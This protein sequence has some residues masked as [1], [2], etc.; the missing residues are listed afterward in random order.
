LLHAA[1]GVESTQGE[2]SS[3]YVDIPEVFASETPEPLMP[4]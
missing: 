2:G 3:F 1:L 4:Q